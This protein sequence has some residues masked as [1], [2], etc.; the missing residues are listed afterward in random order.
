M[1][2]FCSLVSWP[3]SA[4]IFSCRQAASVRPCVKNNARNPHFL[5]EQKEDAVRPTSS[6]PRAKRC[7]KDR[8]KTINHLHKPPPPPP[9]PPPTTSLTKSSLPNLL[10]TPTKSTPTHPTH[11]QQAPITHSL[12]HHHVLGHPHLHM[13]PQGDGPL[14]LPGPLPRPLPRPPAF[15][16]GLRKPLPQLRVV[17]Q[18]EALMRPA[19]AFWFDRL[20]C[21]LVRGGGHLR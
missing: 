13:R 21:S 8:T 1:T 19:F 5:E 11:P 18:S 15:R 2:L 12:T 16:R 14:P 9:P 20:D 10:I 3:V 17:G 6:N 7:S 4:N